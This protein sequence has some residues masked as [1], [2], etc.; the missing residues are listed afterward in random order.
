MKSQLQEKSVFIGKSLLWSLLLYVICM[1]IINKDEIVAAFKNKNDIQMAQTQ[2][3]EG[4]SNT[5]ALTKIPVPK[6][7]TINK[8]SLSL[9]TFENLFSV[10]SKV[11]S[12]LAR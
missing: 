12:V 3:P 9:H 8:N 1:A 2:M 10:I 7:N 4:T 11:T 6:L 5:N